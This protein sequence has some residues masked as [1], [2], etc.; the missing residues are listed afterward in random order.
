MRT[1]ALTRCRAAGAHTLRFAARRSCVLFL[2]CY[3]HGL[4]LPYL[5]QLPSSCLPL[6]HFFHCLLGSSHA[7]LHIPPAPQQFP[8]PPPL[9]FLPP[10]PNA[11]QCPHTPLLP[12]AAYNTLWL[13][14]LTRC[15]RLNTTV[16][17]W[18]DVAGA[19]SDTSGNLPVPSGRRHY[20]TAAGRNLLNA[21]LYIPRA[22]L[23]ATGLCISPPPRRCRPY[24]CTVNTPY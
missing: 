3:A 12:G 1:V 11:R 15:T 24:H 16:W 21:T 19:A 13:L 14:R 17:W 23:T 2:A 22:S 7:A 10:I 5:L 18:R 8:L 4:A 6:P 20:I 9:P